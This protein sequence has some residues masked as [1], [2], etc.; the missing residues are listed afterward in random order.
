MKWLFEASR[1]G[2]TR[3]RIIL[4]LMEHP[5]NINQIARRLGLNY[6][7]IQHHLGVLEKHGIVERLGD[8]YGF[9]YFLSVE[10][11]NMIDYIEES[12]CRVLGDKDCSRSG[13][14]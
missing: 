1:G 12:I 4:L 8:G 7:T 9:P 3:A 6:R 14:Y 10:A 13:T 5:M 11:L 2:P